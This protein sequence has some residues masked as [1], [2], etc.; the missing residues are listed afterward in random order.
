MCLC[1][2]IPAHRRESVYTYTDDVNSILIE[3]LPHKLCLLLFTGSPDVRMSQ[4]SM[5]QVAGIFLFLYAW[6]HQFQCAIILAN[7]RKNSKGQVVTSA[8]KIPRG[9]LFE[10]LSSPHL[11]C[12]VLLYLALSLILRQSPTFQFV[13]FWV[14]SNQI[15]TAFLSHWWYK[16]TFSDYP[17]QRKAFI[18]YVL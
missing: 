12:E 9:G 17:K 1:V 14:A 18:P 4:V 3:N 8:H 16:K 10:L 6:Y 11:T 15:E 2:I 5:S 13:F 7:L